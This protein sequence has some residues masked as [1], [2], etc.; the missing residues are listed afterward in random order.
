MELY[1]EC[2]GVFLGLGAAGSGFGKRA[3]GGGREGLGHAAKRPRNLSDVKPLWVRHYGG[4]EP[5]EA[6]AE[7]SH[8]MR[9]LGI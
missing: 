6:R 2:G 4:P 3:F 5:L 8:I 7:S 9:N 1:P